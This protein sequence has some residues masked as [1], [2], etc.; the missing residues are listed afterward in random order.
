MA[1]LD[2]SDHM[3]FDSLQSMRKHHP[4]WRLL[5]SSQASLVIS[6]LYF[7][8]VAENKR[9]IPEHTLISRLNSYID[10]LSIAQDDIRPSKELLT[11]WADDQHAWLRKFYPVSDDEIHYDLTSSAQKAIEWLVGLKQ[12]SFIGTE[13]R[14]ITVFQLLNEIVEQSDANPERRIIELERRKAEIEEEISRAKSGKIKTLEPIQIKDRFL[15]A[16][17]TAREILA[18]FR[19]VEQNF[20][21]LDRNMREKIASWDKGKGELLNAFFLEQDG[22]N[23][24]EQGKSFDAFWRYLTSKVEQDNFEN[25]VNQVIALEAIKNIPSSKNMLRIE[26]DWLSGSEHVQDTV[27]T[28]SQQL[29]KY[30]D[31][32]FLEEERR[33]NNI[34]KSIEKSAI[35]IRDNMPK[36]D[37]MYI[38][39]VCP[40]ISLPLDRPLFTPPV[41]TKIADDGI[42]D[43]VE[44]GSDDA[45]YSQVYVDKSLLINQINNAL[46]TKNE[47]TLSDII[48]LYPLKLGLSELVTYLVIAGEYSNIIF[49][50]ATEETIFWIDKNNVK[51]H[52]KLPN[53]VFSKKINYSNGTEE[54]YDR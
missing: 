33:I 42:L 28:I 6:F 22:I 38:D 19:A 18:D 23:E 43:G 49:D 45:L 15:Q 48:Q 16:M 4:A 24:S 32:N 26:Q 31:E 46:T 30:V 10:Q 11:Q 9:E 39:G 50:T 37:F 13:S 20:R 47:V 52:A 8:F 35:S 3:S 54:S 7:E 41:K 25:T 2:Y 14:L 21:E 17:T 1:K 27:A 44:F 12:Q 40:G 5:A 51:H 34:I 53:I 36:D 29:R